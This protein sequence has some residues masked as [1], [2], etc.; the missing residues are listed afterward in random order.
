MGVVLLVFSF[1][2]SMFL[3]NP[4]VSAE[5]E[6]IVTV[7]SVAHQIK[8]DVKVVGI[9]KESYIS[10]NKLMADTSDIYYIVM[11]THVSFDSVKSEND[12][13]NYLFYMAMQYDVINEIQHSLD[14][15]PMI[16]LRHGYDLYSGYDYEFTI[17][18][19]KIGD[20]WY[21][22]DGA[23]PQGKP[24]AVKDYLDNALK[25]FVDNSS[26]SNVLNSSWGYNAYS[27]Y[28][29]ASYAL[30]YALSP[31]NSYCFYPGNDC[32]NF[33]SQA[34]H[35]GHI[36]ITSEWYPAYS[37]KTKASLS[38]VNVDYAISYFTREGIYDEIYHGRGT[39]RIPGAFIGMVGY[40]DLNRNGEPDHAVMVTSTSGG[41]V[42]Y[43]AHTTNV[44]NATWLTSYDSW[45]YDVTYLVDY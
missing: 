24:M 37:C 38:W 11:S 23:L 28:L 42:R 20:K 9:R 5:N 7:E 18:V 27:N 25:P 14:E 26:Q 3:V 32:Q 22:L 10:G 30:H 1:F 4:V 31:N 43:S 41:Q 21:A 17:A 33:V 6:A 19:K 34:M 12:W 39:D 29:A 8:P 40:F 36:P 35:A 15:V 16:L 45:L 2:V 44:K 13:Q